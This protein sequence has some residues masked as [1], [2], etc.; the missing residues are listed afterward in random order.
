MV[1]IILN[2]SVS[3]MKNGREATSAI[4]VNAIINTMLQKVK[5][6]LFTTVVYLPHRASPS[7]GI[8]EMKKGTKAIRQ[9]K[10]N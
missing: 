1:A 3:E 2:E 5:Y 6:K 9:S 10:S 4:A 7:Q 8:K